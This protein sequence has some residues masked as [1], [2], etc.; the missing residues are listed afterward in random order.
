M[1]LIQ[2]LIFLIFFWLTFVLLT[3]LTDIAVPLNVVLY[4]VILRIL[5]SSTKFQ[6]RGNYQSI[7]QL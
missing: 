5:A 3:G 2:I 7:T 4:I 6:S 1:D